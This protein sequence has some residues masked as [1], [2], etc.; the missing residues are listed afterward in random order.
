MNYV[1]DKLKEWLVVVVNFGG[2]L[3]GKVDEVFPPKTREKKLRH[4]LQVATPFIISV[5][6]LLLCI[7][8][9]RR[10][11]GREMKMM[12][13][14]GGRSKRMPRHDFEGNPRSYFRSLCGKPV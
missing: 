7:C 10:R 8:Y 2:S 9:N 12:N 6:V 14:P 1:M 11:G 3:I 4:W 13:A 5:V